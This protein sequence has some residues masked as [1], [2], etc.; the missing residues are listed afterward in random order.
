MRGNFASWRASPHFVLETGI[1]ILAIAP[2][3][4]GI[5]IL[6]THALWGLMSSRDQLWFLLPKYENHFLGE[7]LF[8]LAL[9]VLFAIAQIA[10]LWRVF[11]PEVGT[12]A[13]LAVVVLVWACVWETFFFLRK[14]P[15]SA[16]PG[17]VSDLS[18]WYAPWVLSAALLVAALWPRHRERTLLGLEADSR[19]VTQQPPL[20]AHALAGSGYLAIAFLASYLWEALDPSQE[21]KQAE[22]LWRAAAIAMGFFPFYRLAAWSFGSLLTHK[23]PSRGFGPFP[24][25]VLGP[26]LGWSSFFLACREKHGEAAALLAAALSGWLEAVAAVC[27]TVPWLVIGVFLVLAALTVFAGDRNLDRGQAT[28]LLA[29][30]V[31]LCLPFLAIYQFGKPL[32]GTGKAESFFYRW[33]CNRND[34]TVMRIGFGEWQVCGGDDANGEDGWTAFLRVRNKP[35]V[36]WPVAGGDVPTYCLAKIEERQAYVLLPSGECQWRSFLVLTLLGTSHTWPVEKK[37]VVAA[38]IRAAPCQNGQL[39][40][41]QLPLKSLMPAGLLRHRVL[42]VVAFGIPH[43]EVAVV[44]APRLIGPPVLL[45]L[46]LT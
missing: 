18:G 13:R 41:L 39:E 34:G 28:R 12:K 42:E 25:D 32:I 1:L 26:G 27:K 24:V 30:V 19:L 43:G 20:A 8:I 14:D 31:G 5:P 3:F 35:W 22:Y 9:P 7:V 40:K 10:Q 4:L 21:G 38:C 23:L 2:F 46:R 6:A 15:M 16:F 11:L 29:V 37:E 44:Y 45:L 17:A 36:F 33:E